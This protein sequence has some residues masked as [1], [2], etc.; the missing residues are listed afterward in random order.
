MIGSLSRFVAG[1]LAP[2]NGLLLIANNRK[3]LRLAILPFV[4]SL[5]VFV[6]GLAIGLPFVTAQVAP[7]TRGALSLFDVNLASKI[8]VQFSCGPPWHSHSCLFS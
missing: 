5:L 3:L 1:A 8:G 4:A 2:L 6:V 7:L